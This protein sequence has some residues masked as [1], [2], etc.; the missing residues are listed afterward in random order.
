MRGPRLVSARE[1]GQA[2][3]VGFG[4]FDRVEL[5]RGAVIRYPCFRERVGSD[6]AP[7]RGGFRSD[8]S[9]SARASAAVMT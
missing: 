4:E 1:A 7:L 2:G 3:L 6:F 5:V 9:A 8:V